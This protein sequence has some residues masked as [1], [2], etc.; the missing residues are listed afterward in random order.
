MVGYTVAEY[1]V[2]AGGQFGSKAVGIVLS[3]VRVSEGFAAVDK[4]TKATNVSNSFL[5]NIEF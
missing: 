2:F 4:V 5:I 1:V 3:R